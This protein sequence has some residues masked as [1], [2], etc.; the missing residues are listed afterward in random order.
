MYSAHSANS[1]HANIPPR[2]IPQFHHCW[3]DPLAEHE[4][5]KGFHTDA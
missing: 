4:A 2:E 5:G 1:S 3:L